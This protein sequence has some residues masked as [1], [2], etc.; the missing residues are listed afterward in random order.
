MEELRDQMLKDIHHYSQIGIMSHVN[1]DGDGFCASLALQR[2]FKNM[3]LESKI[4][5]DES[6]FE[7]FFYQMDDSVVVEYSPNL[8]FDLLIIMDCNST[9]RLGKRADLVSKAR[10]VI[11]IDHHEQ[12]GDL[13]ENDFC[14]IDTSHVSTGVIL[15]GAL[16][17]DIEQMEKSDRK[18]IAECIYTTILNDTNNF[19]NLNTNSEAFEVSAVLARWGVVPQQMYSKF[20]DNYSPSEMRFIGETLAT[21]ETFYQGRILYM[22][23]TL[24]MAGRNGLLD[25]ESSNMTRWV[26]G[27]RGVDAIIYAREDK[28]GIYRLSLRSLVLNVNAIAVAYGG[29]GHKNASGC[30]ISGDITQIKA[31]LIETFIQELR[32]SDE[33]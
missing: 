8:S 17:N 4:I 22:Q 26:Q 12:E 29:G 10:R 23:S 7:Q 13:I 5:L 30:T 32:L 18:Y 9:N 33:G 25:T 6:S 31:Q 21:V 19:R 24:E 27:L 2:F 14:Y 3:A 15:F 20:F 11:L 16:E 1:P 28:A